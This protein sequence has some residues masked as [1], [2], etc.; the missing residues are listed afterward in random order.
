[1]F[2]ISEVLLLILILSPAYVLLRF[3]FLKRK[4]IQ[5][6]ILREVFLFFLF[7]CVSFVL[8]MTIVPKLLI[9]PDN[10]VTILP[11]SSSINLKPFSFIGE[12]KLYLE[13][14][15]YSAVVFNLFGNIIPFAAISLLC[16]LLFKHFQK[17]YRVLGYGF[18]FTCSIELLQIPL[19]RGTDIDD[20]MLNTFGFMLGYLAYKIILNIMPSFCNRLSE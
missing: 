5:K 14:E 13:M 12:L 10:S 3:L 9:K 16:A 17:F 20:V 19:S 7:C 15:I 4:K 8:V 1:M 2:S 11:G 6:N 18:V